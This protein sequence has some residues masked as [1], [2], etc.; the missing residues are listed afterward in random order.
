MANTILQDKWGPDFPLGYVNV[1]ANGTPVRITVN[2]DAN[3][4]NAPETPSNSTTQEW[5]AKF[6]QIMFQGFKPAANNNG[7]VPN[8]GYVYILRFNA[9]NANTSGNKTDYGVYVSVLGPGQT[10]FLASGSWVND[11][12]SPYRYALDSDSNNEGALV[13]GWAM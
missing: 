6:Q 4:T 3:N 8:T 11:V 7:M 9:N 2:V 10:I 13:T 5:Q 1:T 12:F